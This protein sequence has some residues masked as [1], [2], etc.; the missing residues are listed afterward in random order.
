MLFRLTPIKN[1]EVSAGQNKAN[2]FVLYFSTTFLHFILFKL[3]L[4][5]HNKGKEKDRQHHFTP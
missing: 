2:A 5:K 4:Y 1:C 3:F